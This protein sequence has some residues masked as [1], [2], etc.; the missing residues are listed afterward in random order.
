MYVKVLRIQQYKSKIRLDSE[1]L[2]T[3]CFILYN[4][5]SFS[6]S[7]L[8]LGEQ[9]FTP[10]GNFQNGEQGI[11]FCCMKITYGLFD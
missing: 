11:I 5:Y 9:E 8:F 2:N 10:P 3:M 1:L 6:Y 4:K 7:E